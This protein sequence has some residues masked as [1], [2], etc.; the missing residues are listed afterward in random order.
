MPT[1]VPD[2]ELQRAIEAYAAEGGNAEAT[3]RALGIPPT[4]L[5][6]RM[7]MARRRGLKA[8]GAATDPR[9]RIAQLEKD[10]KAAT[11]EQAD[12][13]ALKQ[14]IGTA[15]MKLD[16]LELPQWVVKPSKDAHAPGVPTLQLSDFHWGERVFPKQVNNVNEFTVGDCEGAASILR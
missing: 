13:Q 15:A 6:T 16:E 14:L 8:K 2:S 12:T 10:L 4:T 7:A 9:K 3:A 5:K 1:P 11:R